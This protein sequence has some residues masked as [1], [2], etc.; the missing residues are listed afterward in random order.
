L[1][2]E[3]KERADT[4]KKIQRKRQELAEMDTDLEMHESML[5]QSEK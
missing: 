4:E 3:K 5:D 1:L 2:K